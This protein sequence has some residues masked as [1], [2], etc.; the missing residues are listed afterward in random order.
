M[1]IPK[2]VGKIAE[3]LR[4]GRRIRRLTVRQ[5]L[6]MFKAERR[7]MIKVQEI[8]STLDSLGLVTDPDFQSAWIDRL[9][10]IRLKGTAGPLGTTAPDPGD[11]ISRNPEP[12][13]DRFVPEGDSSDPN[14]ALAPGEGEAEGEAEG[15]EEETEEEV[16]DLTVEVPSEGVVETALGDTTD[17]TFRIGSF[18]AANKGVTTVCQDDT[19]GKAVTRMLQYDFSQLPIMQGEREVKGVVSWRSI[20]S[21]F[22]LGAECARVRDCRED[23]Q[24]IDANGT[25]FDAI[26]TIVRHGYVLVRNQQDRRITGIVT[27]SDLSLQFQ[28]LAEPF[29]L[30]REIE[31]HIRKLLQDKVSASDLKILASP[32]AADRCPSS[33]ADLSF[34][35]YIRLFQHP[36]IWTKLSLRIDGSCLTAL[37]EEVRKIRNDVMHFDP[38]PM[39]PKQLETLKNAASFMRQLSEL[40]P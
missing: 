39:T 25:L 2:E 35:D 22:A 4:A 18:D 26:P 13:E 10:A 6:R 31:L 36:D 38:D 21:H 23:A 12:L 40:L 11:D 19:V 24:V 5:L 14:F 8:K 17:P 32:E 37:L 27:A 1:W 7:G 33:I 30:L 34:G 3:N 16:G 28:Q 15:A 9:V 29:L 20:G